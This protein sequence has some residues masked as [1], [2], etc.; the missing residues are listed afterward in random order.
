ML[1]PLQKQLKPPVN[2]HPHTNDKVAIVHNG[3]IENF[4]ELREH[5][6]EKG[7]KFVTETDS[8]VI[9]HLISQFMDEGF[10]SFLAVRKALEKLQGAFAL[11][12]LLAGRE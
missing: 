2:A 1:A 9:V 6:S 5:L 7:H 8:E 4:K 3:I 11:G 12:I 10:D